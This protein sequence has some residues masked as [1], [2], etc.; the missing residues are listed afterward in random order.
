MHL[1]LRRMMLAHIH[2]SNRKSV[3]KLTAQ[4][5]AS[6]ICRG[7]FDAKQ[8]ASSLTDIVKLNKLLSMTSFCMIKST[9]FKIPCNK[10]LKSIPQ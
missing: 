6:Q 10:P 1:L 9:P 3:T 2:L 7:R 5:N 4:P 8:I